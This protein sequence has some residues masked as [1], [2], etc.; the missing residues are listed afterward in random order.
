MKDWNNLVELADKTSGHG[1]LFMER[2]LTIH[3]N[4]LKDFRTVKVF[5]FFLKSY[6]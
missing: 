6:F 1:V 4:F 3:S 5:N 2:L